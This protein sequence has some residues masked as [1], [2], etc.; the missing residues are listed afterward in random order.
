VNTETVTIPTYTLLRGVQPNLSN[1]TGTIT[2]AN[3]AGAENITAL[4][5]GKIYVGGGNTGYL[6][7]SDVI[8]GDGSGGIDGN[9]VVTRSFLDGQIDASGVVLVYDSLVGVSSFVNNGTLGTYNS[10]VFNLTDSG[11][12]TN[13][14]TAYDN[15]VLAAGKRLTSTTTQGAIDELVEGSPANVITLNKDE[16]G[17]PDQDVDIVAEQGTENN[18]ILRYDD[19]NNRWEYS[20]DGSTFQALGSVFGTYYSYAESEPISDTTSST[21]SQKLR[22]TTPSLPAGTYRIGYSFEGQNTSTSGRIDTRVQIDDSITIADTFIE[23]QDVVNFYAF[24]GFKHAVLTPGVH[25]IDIDFANSGSGTANIRYA[26]LEI[27][28]VQ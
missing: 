11:T 20:N 3:Q 14:G 9:L 8:L 23:P 1:F 5:T 4:G 10:S 6:N 18:G 13:Y 12:W 2:L 28:R 15:T 22:L 7:N 26:R 27:W 21:Y 25:D 16:T 24:S 19:G 17:N